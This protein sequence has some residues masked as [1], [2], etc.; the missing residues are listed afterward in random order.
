MP[1]LVQKCRS[2]DARDAIFYSYTRHISGFVAIFYSYIRHINSF[3]AIFYSY[4]RHINSFAAILDEKA[5]KIA[6]KL[7]I[8]MLAF[9]FI[10]HYF[11]LMVQINVT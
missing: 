3:D 7:E 11:L 4:T 5:A 10:F 6:S 9:E 8:N 1:G 2:E